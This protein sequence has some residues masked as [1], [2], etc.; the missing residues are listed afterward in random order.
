MGEK[1]RKRQNNVGFR[2]WV[3]AVEPG[4]PFVETTRCNTQRIS[5]II[6]DAINPSSGTVED[7]GLVLALDVKDQAVCDGVAFLVA[8][9]HQA[10]YA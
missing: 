2:I 9:E 7:P 3:I 4:F 1:T 6:F 8:P 5:A 10:R